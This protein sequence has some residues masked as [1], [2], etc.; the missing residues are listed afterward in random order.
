MT[1]TPASSS[2]RP[3]AVVIVT[4]NSSGVIEGCLRALPAALRGTGENVVIVV[5]NASDDDTVARAMRTMPDVEIIR[6][7][8]NGGFATGVN[9][10][11]LAT[12]EHDVVVLNA[13]IRLAPGAVAALRAE[14]AGRP[15]IVVPKLVG[16]DGEI[17]TSLR[18]APTVRRALG[19][20]VLGGTRAGRIQ[21]LGETVT[22]L[23]AYRRPRTVD[24][25]TGAAWL[26]TRECLD[27]VGLLEE[28]YFLY[29]EETEY[30]LRVTD[31]GL[32]VRYTP[33]AVAVHLGGELASSAPLWSLLT[34]N[35]VRLHRERHGRAR[36]AL[37]WPAVALNE[38]L[39]TVRG[40]PGDRRRHRAALRGLF[41]MPTWPNPVSATEPPRPHKSTPKPIELSEGRLPCAE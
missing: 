11:I 25:A 5:D 18:R 30:M 37:M 6:R 19:D 28:R 8:D 34:S 4:Y 23:A 38:A 32:P 26:I 3:V 40:S 2:T 36:A 31:S 9:A 1:P 29:S 13:D 21:V 24:W 10:G 7:P 20:A 41:T 35:R 16:P 14:A 22:D 17:H 39:R 27:Q 33:A 15:G 12:S